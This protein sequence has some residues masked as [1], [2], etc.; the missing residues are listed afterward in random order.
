MSPRLPIAVLAGLFVGAAAAAGASSAVYR[1]GNTYQATP[2][3]GGQAVDGD[4]RAAADVA[5]ARE[6]ATRDRQLAQTMTRDR[7]QA[8]A[9]LRPSAAVSIGPRSAAD[10][11]AKSSKSKTKA[12]KGAK[13]GIFVAA[14]PGSG[15]KKKVK[16]A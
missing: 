9:R 10:A 16:P 6:V 2:C 5:A 13:E 14:V 12:K 4:A 7:E 15:K 11:A 3:P 8:E 1:C